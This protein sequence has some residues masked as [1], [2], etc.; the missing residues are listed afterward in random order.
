VELVR[1]AV[2][3][4]DELRLAA[5]RFTYF[6]LAHTQNRGPNGKLY[7]DRTELS[8]TTYLDDLPYQR[9]V[10]V[11]GKPL[12]GKAFHAEQARYDQAIR[13]RSALDT[14]TRAKL[15]KQLHISLKLPYPLLTTHY[16]LTDL[17]QEMLD[18]HSVHVI[19]ATPL[20][21]SDSVPTRHLRLWIAPSSPGTPPLLLLLRTDF[22]YL[23]PDNGI[24]P[25]SSGQILYTLI[26]TI[27]VPS[28]YEIHSRVAPSGKSDKIIQVRRRAH[29]LSLP[30]VQSRIAHPPHLPALAVNV[31]TICDAET[32]RSLRG[33]L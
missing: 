24:L 25:G 8:E 10:E 2:A 3:A 17:R 11:N 5:P 31:C 7:Y 32:I 9:L 20:P 19:D 27:P 21:A 4:L 26:D 33:M 28:H 1:E 30:P 15:A 16:Q 29:L 23:A 22:D 12:I 6:E 18:G 14:A 13:D